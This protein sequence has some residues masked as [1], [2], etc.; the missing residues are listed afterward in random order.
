MTKNK[1]N[2]IAQTWSGLYLNAAVSH[3]QRIPHLNSGLSYET[4]RDERGDLCAVCGS[5]RLPASYMYLNR[6]RKVEE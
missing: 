1:T 5:D 6:K 4:H 2:P 3:I